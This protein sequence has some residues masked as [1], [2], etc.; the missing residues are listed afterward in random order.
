MDLCG[1]EWYAVHVALSLSLNKRI[2]GESHFACSPPVSRQWAQAPFLVQ[3]NWAEFGLLPGHGSFNRHE[4]VL[5]DFID[6]N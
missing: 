2:K 1:L 5:G 4:N 6:Q 3:T